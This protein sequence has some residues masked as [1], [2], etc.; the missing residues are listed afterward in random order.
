MPTRYSPAPLRTPVLEGDNKL[1][2][3]PWFRYLADI[4]AALKAGGIP[5]VG[6]VPEAPAFDVIQAGPLTATVGVENAHAPLIAEAVGWGNVTSIKADIATD[7]AFSSIVKTFELSGVMLQRAIFTFITTAPGHFYARGYAI[8]PVGQGAYSST[9]EFD[10]DNSMGDSAVPDAPDLAVYNT[11]DIDTVNYREVTAR[12]SWHGHS[13]CRGLWQAAIQFHTSSSMTNPE[14]SPVYNPGSNK[15]SLVQ[16]SDLFTDSTA[17]FVSSGVAIGHWIMWSTDDPWPGSPA[18]NVNIAM[19]TEVVSETQLRMA[20]VNTGPSGSYAYRITLNMEQVDSLVGFYPY[21]HIIGSEMRDRG[22]VDI[23]IALPAGTNW[24][25]RAWV[26]NHLGR[27][28]ASAVTSAF[29]TIDLPGGATDTVLPGAPQNFS[30]TGANGKFVGHWDIPATGYNTL[31][32]VCIEGAD[33]ASF[34]VNVDTSKGWGPINHAEATQPNKTKYCRIAWHNQSGVASDA[35]TKAVIE[36][37]YGAGSADE[38]W[39]PFCSGL[40]A[41]SGDITNATALE[42]VKNTTAPSNSVSSLDRYVL[43]GTPDDNSATVVLYWYYTQGTYK[44]NQFTFTITDGTATY[45]YRAKGPTTT[46]TYS[47][48]LNRLKSSKNVTV[49]IYAEFVGVAG[50]VVGGSDSWNFTPSS[51]Y[52]TS[53]AATSVGEI[54]WAGGQ[55]W[56][57]T[58]QYRNNIA[59]SAAPN[60]GMTMNV[61]Q[62]ES[63]NQGDVTINNLG[64]TPG[65]YPATHMAVFIKEGATS[66]ISLT[67]DPIVGWMNVASLPS[68]FTIP[69]PINARRNYCVGIAMVAVTEDGNS[70]NAT[71]REYGF[72]AG[73]NLSIYSDGG[74]VYIG[75]GSSTTI[76]LHRPTK[77]NPS[78]A[79][80]RWIGFY[81][82]GAASVTNLANYAKLYADTSGGKV[83]LMVIFP[84]G[85]AIN[86]ATEA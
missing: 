7:G 76:E 84:T 75:G 31:D 27:S 36:A 80:N 59:P 9:V 40:S 18:T 53:H 47:L 51:N 79:A 70:Y 57:E 74:D 33:D 44:C 6:E 48:T 60:S 52:G 55:V 5:E 69:Q 19:V 46:G 32:D 54:D 30:F 71:V 26:W 45:V 49:T 58:E 64:Y 85:S 3:R 68:S 82:D 63:A 65:T 16:G 25:A 15:G 78:T 11:D 34:T 13:N 72:T 81:T 73:S 39:G 56:F 12:V 24:Y 8:N 67:A 4:F 43:A 42:Q 17:T 41:S 28:S 22:Y 29:N 62:T 37:K 66:G 2:S 21:V 77:V 23:P 61:A 50:Q 38:G 10:L 86:L 35:T 1:M 83:R 20:N 14:A